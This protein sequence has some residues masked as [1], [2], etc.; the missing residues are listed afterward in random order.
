MG[1]Q[2]T[3]EGGN[4]AAMQKPVTVKMLK[5]AVD[6]KQAPEDEYKLNGEAILNVTIV[7]KVIEASKKSSYIMYKV[8]DGTGV[9]DVKV[10]SE[11]DSTDE[12]AAV[13]AYVRVYGGLK[14]ISNETMISGHSEHAVRTITDFNEVTFHM[15]EVVYSSGFAAKKTTMGGEVPANAYTVPAAQNTAVTG[16]QDS[17]DISTAIIGV[18]RAGSFGEQGMHIDKITEELNG[19]FTRDAVEQAVN[20]MANGG[21]VFTTTD[22]F[23]FA[24]V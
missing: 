22:D 19:R 18:L 13:G 1:G 6:S 23:H 17:A 8:D 7:G 11:S 21:S 16:D 12:L 20:D 10:W 15:L 2:K 14:S 5:K 9:C 4:A 24:L 3:Y